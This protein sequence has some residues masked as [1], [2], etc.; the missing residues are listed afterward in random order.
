M[1]RNNVTRGTDANLSL[2]VADCNMHLRQLW[3]FPG[4]VYPQWE[5]PE[6]GRKRRAVAGFSLLLLTGDDLGLSGT[7]DL[8][9]LALELL[10]H[11]SGNSSWAIANFVLLKYIS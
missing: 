2:G 8:L 3:W 11:L 7:L 5:A 10:G 6:R 1:L 4:T 9:S